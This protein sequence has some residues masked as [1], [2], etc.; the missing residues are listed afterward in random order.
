MVTG[1]SFAATGRRIATLTA[2]RD[3]LDAEIKA[4]RAQH[5]ADA[6]A[7][8]AERGTK[9]WDVPAEP[10][11][12][13]AAAFTVPVPKTTVSVTDEGALLAWASVER[14]E[15]VETVDVPAVP[16]HQVR[17]PAGKALTSLTAAVRAL[18]GGD[19]LLPETGEIVPGLRAERAPVRSTSLRFTPDGREALLSRWRD[20]LAPEMVSA[21]LPA[22][23][24][25]GGPR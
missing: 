23:G 8:Y 22:I 4:E 25:A 21:V 1:R 9:S 20:G 12:D 15:L 19:V 18:P 7:E 5:T 14:P 24:P 6:L 10:G 16:A 11:G 13:V 2:L 3:A 17:R